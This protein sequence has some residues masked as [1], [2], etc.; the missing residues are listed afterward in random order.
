MGWAD[1]TGGLREL[2]LI[3]ECGYLWQARPLTS[4]EDIESSSFVIFRGI[5]PAGKMCYEICK[6]G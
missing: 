6:I 4:S 3:F 5:D 2:A 1:I